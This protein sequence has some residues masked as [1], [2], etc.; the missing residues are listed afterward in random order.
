M[1]HLSEIVRIM[2][3]FDFTVEEYFADG[4]AVVA[5]A[6]STYA[7]AKGTTINDSV[8]HAI[9]RYVECRFNDKLQALIEWQPS[10]DPLYSG[11]R[12]AFRLKD[13]VV[14]GKISVTPKNVNVT[15]L[16]PFPG[17]SGGV[18]LWSAAPQIFTEEPFPGSPANEMGAEDA[19]NILVRLYVNHACSAPSSRPGRF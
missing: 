2:S 12:I 7:K 16:S 11:N 1:E 18:R 13:I 17:V 8:R 6:E 19:R 9:G 3:G 4:R 14:S 10:A 15:M 5:R